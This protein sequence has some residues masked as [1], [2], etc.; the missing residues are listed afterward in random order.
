MKKILALLMAFAMIFCLAAC[1]DSVKDNGESTTEEATTGRPGDFVTDANGEVLLVT[2]PYIITEANG[3]V[4]T[5]K[6]TDEKGSEY[7]MPVT[8]VVVDV[9]TYP[10]ATQAPTVAPGN[11]MAPTGK[12][13]PKDEFMKKLPVLSENVDDINS[14]ATEE[15]NIAILYFNDVSY[16][17]YLKYIEKCKAAGF[18]QT[19]GHDL[20]EKEENGESYI[21]YSIANGLYVGIT[22]NTDKAPYRNCDVKISVADYD[23][24]GI[25]ASINSEK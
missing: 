18:E 8:T 19:Y 3:E 24:A 9:E 23:V 11:T 20:P 4:K 13:W 1:K 12:K 16:A 21:Y 25:N 14:S 22:Y 5:E 2:K 15:G 7:V 17:D 10:G 6:V